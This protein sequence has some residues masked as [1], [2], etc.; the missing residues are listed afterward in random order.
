MQWACLSNVHVWGPQWSRA[1]LAWRSESNS[2]PKHCRPEQVHWANQG[3]QWRQSQFYWAPPKWGGKTSHATDKVHW[4]GFWRSY[5]QIRRKAGVVKSRFWREI[6]PRSRKILNQNVIIGPIPVWH[7]QYRDDVRRFE[8]LCG[9]FES[10]QSLDQ[11]LA[12]VR[13]HLE[14][15]RQYGADWQGTRAWQ[16]WNP[17]WSPF[18]T[19]VTSCHQNSQPDHKV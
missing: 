18:E 19:F 1:S 12:R 14:E 5:T 17:N 3:S 9:S 10:R 7:W 4:W 13:L 6:W 16:L 15:H 11:D 8:Q 2:A